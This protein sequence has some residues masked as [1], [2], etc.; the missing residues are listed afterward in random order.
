[1]ILKTIS[2]RE[3]SYDPGA[4]FIA[5]SNPPELIACSEGVRRLWD[6]PPEVTRVWFV[7]HDRPARQRVSL[8]PL[9][10]VSGFVYLAM[11]DGRPVRISDAL[12]RMLI[13]SG[14]D[15]VFVELQYT[16]PAMTR[17]KKRK[18]AHG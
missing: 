16:A 1:M 12:Y 8:K 2:A 14:R 9:G 7:C 10:R 3:D 18:R 17:R 5:T 13:E 4:D 15:E 6:L 11:V